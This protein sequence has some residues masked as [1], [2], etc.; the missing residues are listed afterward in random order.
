M[1]TSG[2]SQFA[3]VQY[4][5]VDAA[6]A[7]LSKSEHRVAKCTLTVKPAYVKHQPDYK[8]FKPPKQDSPQHILNALNDDC[9][10]GV[11]KQFKLPD[12]SVAADVCVRFQQHAIDAFTLK[13]KHVIK[14]EH[15]A[16]FKGNP[17]K[18]EV[19]L[20][21]FGSLI[22]TLCVNRNVLKA[23]SIELLKMV[24]KYVPTLKNLKLCNFQVAESVN[25]VHSLFSK[26][27]TL[28]LSNC[29]FT[30]GAETLLTRCAELKQLALYDV[31]W[32]NYCID[33]TFPKLEEVLLSSC[34]TI[35]DAEFKKF[36]TSN[37][38]L[39][40][41]SIDDNSELKSVSII[42]AIGKNLQNLVELKID[43]EHFEL[44]QNQFQKCTLTL[45]QLSSLTKLTLNNN[46]F[47]VKLLLNKLAE[48]AVPLEYLSLSNGSIGDDSSAIKS[49]SEL[50]K[51]KHIELEHIKNLTDEHVSVLA[52][53]LPQLREMHLKGKTAEDITTDGLRNMLNHA[54]VLSHLVLQRASN[55][56]IGM[57]DYKAMLKSVQDRAEKIKLVIEITGD[58]DK[59]DV[60]DKVLSANQE[61]LWIDEEIDEDDDD[62]DDGRPDFAMMIHIFL[63]LGRH[64]MMHN[65]DSDEE[66]EDDL[67]DSNGDMN[68]DL[69]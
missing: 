26:L 69:D 3:F 30:S 48:S 14:F 42:Q 20:R 18:F 2:N 28:S 32:D 68:F 45:G 22:Q 65:H 43:Q 41:L 39:K 67:D 51:L 34:S 11:F 31:D 15:V 36:I 61:W 33:H 7:A 54:K 60:P 50:L 27:E 8:A 9:L 64:L 55:V 52:K 6:I 66:T 1:H 56:T 29:A 4:K 19:M 47:S 40:K 35:D 44:R 23:D 16:Q 12:L 59:V 10:E 53:G 5:S 21:N 37:P 57:N 17:G 46:G 38:T 63:G 58:G 62:D 24:N 49:M 13:Y 25:D